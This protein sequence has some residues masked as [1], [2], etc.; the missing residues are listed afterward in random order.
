[1]SQQVELNEQNVNSLLQSFIDKG[2]KEA[3]H[4]GI[5]ERAALHK[6]FLFLHKVEKDA[7]MTL[8]EAYQKVFNALNQ[9]AH[10]FTLEDSS[11][12]V[13][14]VNFV[15]TKVIPQPEEAE[16]PKIKEL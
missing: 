13:K 10:T 3:R 14:C 5:V 11:N 16:E 9:V 4:L 12:I 6:V 8:T 1:M 2:I 15:N 7:E